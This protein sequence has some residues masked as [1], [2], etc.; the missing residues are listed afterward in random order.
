MKTYDSSFDYFE[1]LFHNT[2][3][4]TVLLM[5]KEGTIMS[6]NEKVLEVQKKLCAVYGCPIPY[7]HE[8]D[9]LS[10]LVSREARGAQYESITICAT[11]WF[12]R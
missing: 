2:V 5:D 8:L 4:N 6:I 10:E 12:A 1:S 11:T 9:P 3:E 7:F